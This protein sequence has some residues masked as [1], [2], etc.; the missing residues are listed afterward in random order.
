MHRLASSFDDVDEQLLEELVA[1]Y[2][3]YL[4]SKIRESTSRLRD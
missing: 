3:E 2:Y 4:T 1:I